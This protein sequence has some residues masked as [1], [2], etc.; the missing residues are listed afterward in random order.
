MSLAV[1]FTNHEQFHQE[2]LHGMAAGGLAA[3]AMHV[4]W[5]SFPSAT[6][7]APGTPF[8]LGV[9]GATVGC[10]IRSRGRF[11]AGLLVRAI[12]AAFAA[13]ALM[14]MFGKEAAE[15]ALGVA[16]WAAVL[17]VFMAG[18]AG[19]GGRVGVPAGAVGA[20]LLAALVSPSP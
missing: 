11:Q 6:S 10:A 3:L 16:A 7:I 12:L 4:A 2:T 8:T 13:A 9:L 17:A 5:L 1:R 15:P 19:G 20:L 18:G 14:F